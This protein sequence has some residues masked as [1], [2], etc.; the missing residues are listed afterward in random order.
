MSKYSKLQDS[1]EKRIEELKKERDHYYDKYTKAIIDLGVLK[2]E[3]ALA[4]GL[5]AGKI[6]VYEQLLKKLM[7]E[8]AETDCYF[9]FEGK[10]YRAVDFNLSRSEGEQDRLSVEFVKAAEF[11]EV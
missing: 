8:R 6:E 9:I 5:H 2:T 10:V 11:P 7:G 4:D 1:C 3:T